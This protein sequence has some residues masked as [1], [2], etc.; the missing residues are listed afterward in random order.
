MDRTLK[1]VA[2]TPVEPITTGWAVI[3]LSNPAVDWTA[4]Q[5]TYGLGLTPH[6]LVVRPIRPIPTPTPGVTIVPPKSAPFRG[7][8][9]LD[10]QAS[11]AATP[12]EQQALIVSASGALS[13]QGHA[14]VSALVCERL[15]S[16]QVT[17][18][19]KP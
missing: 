8:V 14:W 6:S 11:L 3:A 7:V 4:A 10:L 18:P 15:I 9:E 1:A 13:A 5:Q 19:A 2:G 12:K 17:A 16:L